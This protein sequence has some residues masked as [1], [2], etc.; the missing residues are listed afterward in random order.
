M[1]HTKNFIYNGFKRFSTLPDTS[2][3]MQSNK[4]PIFDLQIIYGTIFF[5]ISS[6][7]E[8]IEYSFLKGSSSSLGTQL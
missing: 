1:L 6:L 4:S 2:N 3:I 5:V 8:Q 7:I